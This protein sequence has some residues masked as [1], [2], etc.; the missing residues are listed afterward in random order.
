MDYL[1][2]KKEIIIKSIDTENKKW[3]KIYTE[4]MK[5]MVSGCSNPKDK[6]HLTVHI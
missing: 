5:K 6:H 3:K 4:K 2:K 1:L